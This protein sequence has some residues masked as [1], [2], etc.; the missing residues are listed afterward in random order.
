MRANA[1][2][3]RRKAFPLHFGNCLGQNFKNRS[4]STNCLAA[5]VIS[6]AFVVVVG[7]VPA[8]AEVAVCVLAVFALASCDPKNRVIEDMKDCFPTGWTCLPFMGHFNQIHQGDR[9][10]FRIKG[11]FLA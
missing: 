2:N 3:C 9:R 7:P 1:F 6:S 11:H 4:L 8:E 5:K 10:I